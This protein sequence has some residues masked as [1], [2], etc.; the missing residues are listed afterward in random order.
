MTRSKYVKGHYS[1]KC[2]LDLDNLTSSQQYSHKQYN[3]KSN[4]E[5]KRKNKVIVNIKIFVTDVVMVKYCFS[6]ER[7]TQKTF[8]V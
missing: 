8:M 1:V 5:I 2:D 4:E 3:L 6:L 7:A